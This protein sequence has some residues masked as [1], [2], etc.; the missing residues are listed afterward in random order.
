[1]TDGKRLWL[2]T[3]ADSGSNAQTAVQAL[4]EC[5]TE[6]GLQICY[7]T[8]FPEEELPSP[9]M[10]DA[11]QVEI[12]AI[13]AGDGTLNAA[14]NAVA[15]WVGKAL[16]LPG[17]T[18]NLLYRRLFGELELEQAIA[19][20]GSGAALSCRPGVIRC[21]TGTAYAGLLA[22]PGTAW[23][24]VREAIRASDL[25]DMTVEARA[26]LEET[27]AG[28]RVAC[29]EPQLGDPAGYPL[30]LLNP[31]DSAIRVDAYHSET[32]A[33][34]LAQSWALLRRDFRDGP[35]T[36][37]GKVDRLVIRSVTGESFG[38]LIDGEPAEAKGMAEFV[39]A[40]AE[41]DMLSAAVHV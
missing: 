12:V 4:E 2:I 27:L 36:V 28:P 19:Q 30:L 13:F 34:Y 29:T 37:L 26:A 35:H 20:V 1:M 8:R 32:T 31:G 14:L 9:D 6:N 5:L 39:L 23:N 21:E 3:N 22:G 16:I 15:G 40:T 18:M 10:L 17:G 41:V 24:G 33:D 38:I 11:A 7:R 25:V